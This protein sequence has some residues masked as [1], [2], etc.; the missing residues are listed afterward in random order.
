[1]QRRC[2]TACE[3][4][5]FCAAILLLKGAQRWCAEHSSELPQNY[6]EKAAFK[7][8]LKSWQR[9]ADGIPADV[10]LHRS[11]VT[12]QRLGEHTIFLPKEMSAAMQCD[13]TL[14]CKMRLHWL[15]QEENFDEALSNA[16]KLFSPP[17]I[18]A[19]CFNL[20]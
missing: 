19:S 20:Y 16:H 14:Q 13:Y 15:V 10:S 11:L 6:K 1:M 2:T 9:S 3:K 4:S 7:Q 12:T 5:S 18:R 17:S 8:M